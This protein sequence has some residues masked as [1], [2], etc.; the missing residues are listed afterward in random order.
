MSDATQIALQAKGL[1]RRFG[2]NLVLDG[3]DLA[4]PRGSV[5]GLL[6]RNAAGKTT[7][8]RILTGT[9]SA[10]KGEITLHGRS[11][12]RVDAK[13]RKQ[14]GYV[15]QEQHFYA[16]M[17]GHQ[18]QKFVRGFFPKWSDDRFLSVAKDLNVDLSTTVG[19]MSTGTRSKLAFAIALAHDP[20]LLVLDEPTAGVDP[21]DRREILDLVRRQASEHGRTV[22]FSTHH[23]NEVEEIGDHVGVLHNGKAVFSGALAAVP[24]YFRWFDGPLPA[25]VRAVSAPTARGTLGQAPLDVWGQL[26]AAEP[27]TLEELFTVATRRPSD[28]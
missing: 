14:I 2:K 28:R 19:A 3:L 22:L 16:W 9:L 17:N 7:T 21:I 20:K 10:Q 8:L 27:A 24:A 11:V 5:F 25:G 15:S 26:P 4:V 13:M 12:R 18:L 6:G 1:V 23:I